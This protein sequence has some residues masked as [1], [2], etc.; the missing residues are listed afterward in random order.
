MTPPVPLQ[1]PTDDEARSFARFWAWLSDVRARA[2]ERGLTFRAY[3][4]NALAENRWLYASVERFAGE[5]GVPT[6]EEMRR[7][8]GG[9]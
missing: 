8:R 2:A 5:P 1:L 4:Y 9:G 3:C 7:L 6:R